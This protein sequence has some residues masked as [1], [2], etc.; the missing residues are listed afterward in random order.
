[1]YRKRQ[2]HSPYI[3]EC[4]ELS[5]DSEQER[6][7]DIITTRYTQYNNNVSIYIDTHTSMYNTL[8]RLGRQSYCYQRDSSILV[9]TCVIDMPVR[10]SPYLPVNLS[11]TL[12]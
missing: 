6:E 5:I 7:L 3:G 4:T 2:D 10:A 11:P 8:F 9:Y 12:N 1:M